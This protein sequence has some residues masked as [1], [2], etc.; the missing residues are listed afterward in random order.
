LSPYR[1]LECHFELSISF[2]FGL[3]SQRLSHRDSPLLFFSVLN[4]T[5]PSQSP[6]HHHTDH[7]S[8][9]FSD[10]GPFL[11]DIEPQ[12]PLVSLL[13]FS[14]S[15]LSLAILSFRSLD[16]LTR[17]SFSD[18]DTGPSFALL[19]Q[20]LCWS[21]IYQQARLE[22]SDLNFQNVV[23]DVGRVVKYCM[24]WANGYRNR[25]SERVIKVRDGTGPVPI[26]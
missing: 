26:V 6:T 22:K 21:F 19:L 20:L 16:S 13:R 7:P 12:P 15:R 1:G 18:S 10:G 14:L 2:L 11:H 5:S 17:F 4:P 3:S 24:E 23:Q 9:S 25:G 8:L